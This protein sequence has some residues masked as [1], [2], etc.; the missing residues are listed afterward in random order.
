MLLIAAATGIKRSLD[1]TGLSLFYKSSY[2]LEN[3]HATASLILY[4]LR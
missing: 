1:A 4:C 3:C 2:R